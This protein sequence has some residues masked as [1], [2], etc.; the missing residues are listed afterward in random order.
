M[1]RPCGVPGQNLFNFMLR[2]PGI[3]NAKVSSSREEFVKVFHEITGREDI[4][5]GELVWMG[6]WT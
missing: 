5:F 6:V 4:D 1:M 2:S 3:D